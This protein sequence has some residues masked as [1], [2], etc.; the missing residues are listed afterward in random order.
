MNNLKIAYFGG[1]PIGVPVLEELKAAN[2]LP[3]L[4]ICNPDRPAGRGKQLAAPPVKAWAQQHEIETWQPINLKDQTAVTEKLSQ[5]DLFV[6]V[7]YNRILPEWLIELPKYKT[8]NVHPS[9]LPLLRGPSPIRTAILEDNR[10]AVG[11]SVM[12][13]DAA[14]DHGPILAQQTLPIIDALWPINGLTLDAALANLGGAL[15]A[16]TIP[17]WI[18]GDISPQEQ[19]H[20]LATYTQKLS[21]A[22]GELQIDPH[23]LPVGQAA[24]EAFLKIQAYAGWPG[25]FFMHNDIR[26]KITMAKCLENSLQL[27]TII[28]E[29]KKS[30]DFK[31]WIQ[32]H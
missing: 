15:L 28:P 32:S 17:E 27:T 13:M 8:L 31:T 4:I 9:L 1:E 12:L 7:A 21:K 30:I 29:G 20:D 10:D 24:H 11:V 25:T 3:D 14:M 2:I 18:A 16:A 6:V 26:I 19:D 22:D 5:Y 23:H